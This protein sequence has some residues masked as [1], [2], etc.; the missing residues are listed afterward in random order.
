MVTTQNKF[1]GTGQYWPQHYCPKGGQ[2]P[3]TASWGGGGFISTPPHNIPTCDNTTKVSFLILFAPPPISRPPPQTG[4]ANAGNQRWGKPALPL[5]SHTH[6]LW[7]GERPLI[8][9]SWHINLSRIGTYSPTEARQDN[10]VGKCILQTSNNFKDN[11]CSSWWGIH[12]ESKLHIC[13]I[14]IRD[15]GLAIVSFLY[16]DSTFERPLESRL[17]D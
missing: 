15:L 1:S 2:A 7:D 10:S 4:G 17:D 12:M 3:A 14:C 5:H 8:S 9:Q 11:T 16:G 13:Y 6:E